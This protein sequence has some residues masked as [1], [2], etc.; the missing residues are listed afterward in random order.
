[1][2]QNHREKCHSREHREQISSP[3]NPGLQPYT[4]ARKSKVVGSP[5]RLPQSSVEEQSNRKREG[6]HEH[7]HYGE[8]DFKILVINSGNMGTDLIKRVVGI[9]IET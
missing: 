4:T 1:M 5:A 7:L 8:E 6:T 9:N 3:L 2:Y